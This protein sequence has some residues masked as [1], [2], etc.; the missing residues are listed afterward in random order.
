LAVATVQTWLKSGRWEQAMQLRPARRRGYQRR[1]V[2]SGQAV[3]V[4]E[5]APEQERA[6][7]SAATAGASKAVGPAVRQR[8]RAAQVPDRQSA[9]SRTS[10]EGGT[11]AASEGGT[12]RRP[13]ASHPWRKPWSVRQQ[14][15]QAEA[16]GEAQVAPAA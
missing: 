12:A 11:V 8:G 15:R 10:L 14:C 5:M 4:P 9:S 3:S 2:A 1:P 6:R 13:A 16:R 7:S